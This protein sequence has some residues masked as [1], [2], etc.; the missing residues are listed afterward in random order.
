MRDYLKRYDLLPSFLDDCGDLT[1]KVVKLKKY[2]IEAKI[3]KLGGFTHGR[4]LMFTFNDIFRQIS[5]I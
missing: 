2:A 3:K 5:T 4:S 1:A